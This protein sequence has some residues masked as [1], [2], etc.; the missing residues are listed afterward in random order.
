MGESVAGR[1]VDEVDFW[2]WLLF[3]DGSVEGVRG[4]RSL[5]NDGLAG[6][7]FKWIDGS[8]CFL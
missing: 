5:G 3:V 8:F 6:G 7:V 1:I 2:D 4:V